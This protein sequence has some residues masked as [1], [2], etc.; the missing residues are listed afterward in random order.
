MFRFARLRVVRFSHDGRHAAPQKVV[1]VRLLHETVEQRRPRHHLHPAGQALRQLRGLVELLRDERTRCDGR[2]DLIVESVHAD[3]LPVGTGDGD[4]LAGLEG[5]RSSGVGAR[6]SPP[7]DLWRG[8]EEAAASEGGGRPRRQGAATGHGEGIIITALRDHG[9]G[10]W[11]M[12]YGILMS[13]LSDD[14]PAMSILHRL[15]RL[16]QVHTYC[17]MLRESVA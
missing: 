2:D 15:S 8:E 14:T 1:E 3:S 4:R 13:A 10:I 6:G 5:P 17:T 9:G 11:H 7:D 12:A 16:Y